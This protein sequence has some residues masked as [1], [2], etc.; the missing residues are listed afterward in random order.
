MPHATHRIE[1]TPDVHNS[2]YPWDWS[3]YALKGD[4][5]LSSGYAATAEECEAAARAYIAKETAPAP[6]PRTVYT[7]SNGETA[8]APAE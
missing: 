6:A 8:E 3:V 5:W 2:R 1:I 4:V 7:D